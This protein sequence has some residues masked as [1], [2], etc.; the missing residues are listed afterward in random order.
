VQQT[1]LLRVVDEVDVL[2]E[3]IADE[4]RQAHL[5]RVLG[6]P[7][8]RRLSRW[9]GRRDVVPRPGV[10]LH[11][12]Q[13]DRL[14]RPA[15]HEP[16][17]SREEARFVDEQTRTALRHAP[18]ENVHGEHGPALAHVR[19]AGA[20]AKPY[21]ASAERTVPHFSLERASA[22]GRSSRR[23]GRFLGRRRRGVSGGASVCALG[24]SA[25]RVRC[26]SQRRLY[27]FRSR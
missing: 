12:R 15:V 3:P 27:E 21:E 9:R 13:S 23:A 6:R 7:S 11:L 10:L 8:A 18:V 24:H 25:G 20:R 19:R 4:T 1:L 16:T 14:G 17:V 5:H 2:M 26:R 22:L